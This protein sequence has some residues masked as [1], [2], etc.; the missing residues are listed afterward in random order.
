MK[1]KYLLI[2]TTLIILLLTPSVDAKE[3][4]VLNTPKA[5]KDSPS[6]T[7]IASI[8]DEGVLL[9]LSKVV[10]LE[11]T[12]TSGYG[13]RSNWYKV[14]YQDV[15]GYICSSNQSII[16]EKD[17]DL[18]ADFEKEM[19]AKGFNESY[20]S[21]LK[22]LHEK[23]PNWIFNA[24]KTNLD[25]NEAVRNE[26]IGEISLINGTDES[27]RKKD[28]YGNYIESVKEKGWYQASAGAVSY[29]M[30]PRNF[31]TDEGI[32]MFEN[33]QYNKN[34]QTQDTV[35]SITSNTF[36]NTNEYLNYF[37]KA[38]EKSGASPT[39]LASRVKQEKGA[40]GSTGVDGAKFTFSKDYECI[41]RY[42]NSD[43]WTILNNCGTDTSYS[44]IYN[45]YNIG[46]YGSYQSPVI[47]G[48]IWANGGYDG[49]VTSYMRPW[50]SKEKAIIGGSL[51]IVNG[52]IS[53][54]QHTLYLQKFNVSPN[55]LNS[56]YTHQYMSNIKAPVS[57]ALTM[58]KSYKKNDLLDKTY[59]FL[60]P[61]YENMPGVSET[62]KTDDDKPVTP[63]EEVP[64]IKIDDAIIA[65]R[66][67]L[68]SNYISGI[69][70]NTSKTNL[71][72]TLKTIY[73]GLSVV[74]LKDKYGNNKNDALATGDVV[75]ISN[76]KDTKEYK[77][78]IYGDNNGDG[79]TSIIDLLR[80]QKYLL[81]NNNLSDAELIASDVDKD[82]LITVVDL[83]RIQKT[84]LG[85]N[86]IEQK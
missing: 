86:K 75:S 11:K 37:M 61:V 67:R 34:V 29:Y 62:P 78:V 27:L 44:G 33:L 60:I 28:E 54:N 20:L 13:C 74:S 2:L 43:N 57:E 59:E 26:T 8:G 50:D 38:A 15:T 9:T 81:G 46:A 21:A 40:N 80:V 70:V 42:R 47:R 18:E 30:D 52:Y 12:N 35:K 39:Y 19:L 77:V 23:H 48:L 82:G 32:F 45:F 79:N 7:R 58:Y 85:Y 63:P 36:M 51:Y 4:I 17:V 24:L 22:T 25:Y 55:A 14:S 71:E 76:S 66:Y 10:V 69:E 73:N 16:E 31:L 83:L 65:S 3:Y 53:V 64:V 84:L 5:F 6:G 56:T 68:N 1:N 72:N 41:N 49:S